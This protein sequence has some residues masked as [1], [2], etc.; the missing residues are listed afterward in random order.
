MFGKL[1]GKAG[2]C[3]TPPAGGPPPEN[4]A[5]DVSE[6]PWKGEPDYAACNFALGHLVQNLQ[7]ILTTNGRLHAETYVAATGAIAGFAAQCTLFERFEPRMGENINVVTT[8]AGH[9]YW[10]GDVLNFMLV[11]QSQTDA[12]TRVWSIA[13][14]AAVSSG[15]PMGKVPDVGSMFSYVASSL[16]GPNEGLP[17]TAPSHL[18]QL[19]GLELLRTVWPLALTCFSGKF[20]GAQREFG[21]ASLKWWSAIAARACGRPIQEVKGVLPPD[22]ALTILM[23]TAIYCSKLDRALVRAR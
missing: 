23:Q 2:K 21:T 8:T 16:G 17:S 9:N 1:F 10:F 14:G 7:R 18:P 6:F 4:S 22:V 12:G 5:V 20:P 15:L 13:A 11:P 3:P 19:A